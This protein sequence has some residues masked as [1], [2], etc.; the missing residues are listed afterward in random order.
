MRLGEV[1]TR[2]G[3]LAV[4]KIPRPRVHGLVEQ[5]KMGQGMGRTWW[6]RGGD[7]TKLMHRGSG[8]ESGKQSGRGRMRA[9]LR[10]AKIIIDLFVHEAIR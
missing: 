10:L 8:E 4:G 9:P 2:V 5:R 1:R 6:K 3:G 7:V